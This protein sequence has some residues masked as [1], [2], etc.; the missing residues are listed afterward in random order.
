MAQPTKTNTKHKQVS[1]NTAVTNSEAP[2]IVEVDEKIADL[3]VNMWAIGITTRYSCQ[4][5][6]HLFV[7]QTCREGE[8]YR[9]YVLMK[10][11]VWSLGF[12]QELLK[13]YPAFAAE[14][15]AWEIAFDRHPITNEERITIYFPS[16]EIEALT[17]AIEGWN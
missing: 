16:N 17:S 15:C 4:G 11:D 1:I 12:I 13:T 8:R 7:D 2:H 6:G 3:L 14:K 5:D 9:A 10:R